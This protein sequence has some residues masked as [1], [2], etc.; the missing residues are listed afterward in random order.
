MSIAGDEWYFLC[1]I[2]T[3][4]GYVMMKDPQGA[5]KDRPARR[6]DAKGRGVPVW[7]VEP[8]SDVRTPLVDFFSIL[9]SLPCGCR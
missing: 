9:L 5:Q 1:L 7:Y 2:G 6:S 3:S 4:T 8:L